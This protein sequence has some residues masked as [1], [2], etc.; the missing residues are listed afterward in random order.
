MMLKKIF[1]FCLLCSASMLSAQTATPVGAPSGCNAEIRLNRP[2]IYI[3]NFYVTYGKADMGKNI[4]DY[5]AQRFESDGRFEIVPRAA[6]SETMARFLAGKKIKA[7][8][9]LQRTLE[10]AAAENADCVI[11]GKISKKKNKVSFSV[12]MSSVATGA[13]ARKVDTDVERDAALGFLEGIGD[14]FVSYFVSTAPA[15]VAENNNEG[16]HRG[17]HLSL[18]ASSGYLSA[19]KPIGS[20][21]FSVDSFAGHAGLKVGAAIRPDVI[22]FGAFDGFMGFSPAGK[23]QQS[24]I[25]DAVSFSDLNHTVLTAGAG[26]KVYSE[27]NYF[28]SASLAFATGTLGYN[29]N[30]VATSGNSGYG[31]AVQLSLG[32]EWWVAK[33][34][35]IGLALT[36]HY[37]NLPG[38]SVSINQY[39]AGLGISASYN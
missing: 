28:F 30:G 14:S 17:F 15:P 24:G 8:E 31:F 29:N 35:G 10:L 26:L 1:S 34:L 36:G 22:L 33:R 2:K 39:Y 4:G 27:E 9:Y 3:A 5:I 38:N 20:D 12:R 13:S 25:P 21:S 23:L 37:S 32:R 19:S 16:R 11:F 6:I 7:D 18:A